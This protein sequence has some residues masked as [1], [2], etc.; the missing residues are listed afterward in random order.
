MSWINEQENRRYFGF[1]AF[2]CLL[3][4]VFCLWSGWMQGVRVRDSLFQWEGAAASSLL[5][6]GIDRGT[7]ARAFGSEKVTEEGES[8]LRMIG[9]TEE[10]V[11]V[12]FSASDEAVRSAVPLSLAAGA[13]FSLL[14]LSGTVFYME[15]RERELERAG[16]VVERYAAGDFSIRLARGGTGAFGHLLGKTDQLATALKAKSE[17]E[18]QA[19]EF[20]KD[21]VT[22]IS[23]QLKTPLAALNMYAEI[24]SLEPE[25]T[26]TVKEFTE[27][28]LVSLGRMER[29]VYLLLKMMRLDAGS[30]TFTQRLIRVGE[31]AET[32]SEDLLTRAEK[33]GKRLLF[34]GEEDALLV[35]DLDWTAEALGNLVKN[36]LDHT[37]EGGYVRVSWSVSPA[38][39]RICVEDDGSGIPPEEIHHIFKRFYRSSS[40]M[41]T[42]GIGLGL[43][44]AKSIVEGQGG[45]L[46]VQSRP[47]K[48]T[49]FTMAFPHIK[50]AWGKTVSADAETVG[51]TAEEKIQHMDEQDGR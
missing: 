37:K 7:V 36:G 45:V 1:A 47:G 28:S 27:K 43:P 40:S 26:E 16:K 19:K 10:N 12:L 6:Q 33:E 35:C 48:G 51:D 50:Q 17:N 44:L 39:V 18:T 24:I 34:E 49:V 8:L 30:V 5:E 3:L 42:Q 31:L 21:T 25:K 13:V 14:F 41:D 11:P 2:L 15:R 22:D 38:M 9:H 4:M 20:L 29:L 32:A 23:H 46:S